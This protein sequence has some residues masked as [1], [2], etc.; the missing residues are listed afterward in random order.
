MMR[1]TP[2][3]PGTISFRVAYIDDAGNTRT[4]RGW[5]VQSSS[6]L[7]P[8]EGGLHFGRHVTA[9]LRAPASRI[10]A[11]RKCTRHRLSSAAE[12]RPDRQRNPGA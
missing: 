1:M 3:H 7:G 8:Y 11:A 6:T 4:V 9:D 5:R 10:S 2:P 12:R